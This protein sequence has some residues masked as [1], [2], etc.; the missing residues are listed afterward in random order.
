MK[1]LHVFI[2]TLVDL[3]ILNTN[4]QCRYVVYRSKHPFSS[5]QITRNIIELLTPHSQKN[6]NIRIV[7]RIRQRTKF[8][9][10]RNW[11]RTKTVLSTELISSRWNGT[12]TQS[13]TFC[14]NTRFPIDSKI[15]H[16]QLKWILICSSLYVSVYILQ[17]NPK[18]VDLTRNR[19]KVSYY[20]KW[21]IFFADIRCRKE[22]DLSQLRLIKKSYKFK[23]CPFQQ[24]Q[25]QR[26][27]KEK[28]KSF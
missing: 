12:N 14:L 15:L 21:R 4:N 5:T 23:F 22:N 7:I 18:R 26:E 20:V 25:Q 24:Q 2:N 1:T 27:K 8:W 17:Y 9:E 13:S 10:K 3:A 16:V 19:R 28:F 6:K 11:N